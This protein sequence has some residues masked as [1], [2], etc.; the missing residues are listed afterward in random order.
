MNVGNVIKI[1]TAVT[2]LLVAATG[3]VK[4]VCPR[5]SKTKS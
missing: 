2:A 1:L 3:L 5:N 4:E